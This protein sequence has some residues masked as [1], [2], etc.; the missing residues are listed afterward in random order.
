M[1][2]MTVANP[3]RRR[4]GGGR[5]AR[6]LTCPSG[7]IQS[8]V[9]ARFTLGRRIVVVGDSGS[10]KSTAGVQYQ[11][12]RSLGSVTLIGKAFVRDA[13]LP[14]LVAGFLAMRG[15]AAIAGEEGTRG[16]SGPAG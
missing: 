1:V 5:F 6:W 12:S 10:G 13:E 2:L 15:L 4:A 9:T 14:D 8:Q 16:S 3:C 7:G 11:V